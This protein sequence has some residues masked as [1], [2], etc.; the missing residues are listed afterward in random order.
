M[1][2]L[3]PEE[4]E[5]R[6]IDFSES[7]KRGAESG[8]VTS[9][10]HYAIHRLC[11]YSCKE[12]IDSRKEA[13]HYLLKAAEAGIIQA[14]LDLATGYW[15]RFDEIRDKEEAEY[16]ILCHIQS[17]REGKAFDDF[18]FKA[19]HAQLP[20]RQD[21]TDYEKALFWLSK[22]DKKG[23][24]VAAMCLGWFSETG[25]GG[26]KKDE[27]TALAWY[28]KSAEAGYPPAQSIIGLWYADKKLKTEIPQAETWYQ[29]IVRYHPQSTTLL[30]PLEKIYGESLKRIVR[31]H[32]EMEYKTN[33]VPNS[34]HPKSMERKNV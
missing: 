8:D 15:F 1:K 3:P 24:A 19:A 12:D 5:S 22:L 16:L 7:M 18:D 25:T 6:N 27:D 17:M 29:N 21:M 28:R 4:L 10:F 32:H 2:P 33:Q 20:P 13:E 26:A 11:H 34:K 23:D 30:S 31:S 14:Q 9:M